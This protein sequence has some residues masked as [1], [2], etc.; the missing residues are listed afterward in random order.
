MRQTAGR[1][2]RR[3]GECAQL[4]RGVSY[5]KSDSSTEPVDGWIP[6]L[7][8]TNIDGDLDFDDL[9]YVHPRHVATEQFLRVGDVVVATS[10]GSRSQVGKAAPLREPWHGSFGA[11]CMLVRPAAGVH[12]DFLGHFMQS[13]TYRDE[14]S[15]LAAGVNIHNLRRSHLEDI[16][17][18]TPP[19]EQQEAIARS[20][21]A[22]VSRLNAGLASIQSAEESLRRYWSAF[23]EATFAPYEDAP[24]VP[25]F[26]FVT[27]GSRGWAKHYSA[28][29]PL[30]IRMGNL[31]RTSI[32][33]RFEKVQHVRVPSHAEGRRTR[34]VPGDLLV[35]ITADTGMIG[36]VPEGLGEAYVNQHVALARVKEALE[37][38]FVAWYLTSPHGQRMLNRNRRGATK[39]GLGLDDVRGVQVPD[40]S[41]QAQV[42]LCN[43]IE[44]ELSKVESIEQQ[45]QASRMRAR[46]LRNAILQEGFAGATSSAGPTGREMAR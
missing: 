10:S 33:L 42:E 27:S 31:V 30:F 1:G 17:V 13:R 26:R 22:Q 18:P 25:P 9:V 19:L 41:E 37:P 11:F 34:L 24:R 40:L 39:A 2:A 20:I 32:R 15:R 3:L 21:D 4:I 6:I 5:P 36:V 28:D 12:P 45:L 44:G 23:L 46:V 14:M 35:S 38:T 8:A 43:V 29:G 7:R 16:A